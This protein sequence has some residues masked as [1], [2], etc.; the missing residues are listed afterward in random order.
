L[1]D[2]KQQYADR[3]AKY[4]NTINDVVNAM[5]DMSPRTLE[6]IATLDFCYRWIRAANK[7]GPWKTATIEKFK[8]IKKEKFDD[9]EILRW[10]DTLVEAKLIES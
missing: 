10:Y 6:L 2:V 9:D 7:T 5:G 3:L 1:P 4:E 8:Q